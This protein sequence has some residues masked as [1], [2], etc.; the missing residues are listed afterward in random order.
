M[1]L[2][3][4]RLQL[5]FILFCL[6]FFLPAVLWFAPASLCAK[7]QRFYLYKRAVAVCLEMSGIT[8]IYEKYFELDCISENYLENS[9]LNCSTA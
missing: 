8:V 7:E 9:E 4:I 6:A 3:I 1:I 5:A 2:I